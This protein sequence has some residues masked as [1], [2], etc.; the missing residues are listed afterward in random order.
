VCCLHVDRA[1]G[2]DRDHRGVDRPALACRP[3]SPRGCQP[4]PLSEQLPPDRDRR[5]LLPRRHGQTA[6]PVRDY[7]GTKNNHVH[8][9][10]LP[11][12]EYDNLAQSAIA[13]NGTD[14][15]ASNYPA[16]QA[17]ALAGVKPY[18][19]PSDPSINLANGQPIGTSNAYSNVSGAASSGPWPACT[20][21]AANGQVFGVTTG[22]LVSGGGQTVSGGQGTARMP[23]TFQDG[24]S[25]TILFAEHY[26]NTPSTSGGAVWGR[27]L[28][29]NSTYA[30][31]FAVLKT[32]GYTFQ[33]QPTP[34]TADNS[35]PS[36]PHSG[37]INVIMGD[38]SGRS[39]ASSVSL[40]T[41]WAACTPAGNDLLGPD[42]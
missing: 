22:A 14:Y 42:W 6:A 28:S 27:N 34:A 5:Q 36:S 20:S 25:N 19:C 40:T 41:W 30:P 33:P 32:S 1:A 13:A 15:D 29:Y 21:Y 17:A 24:V 38:G 10:L 18:L 16:G 4:H 11:Y 9:W 23:A 35:W 12:L 2:G 8:Y 26:G 31:N 37:V 7:K 3:E 39:V